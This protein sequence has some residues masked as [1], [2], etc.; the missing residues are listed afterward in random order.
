[1][2]WGMMPFRTYLD[3]TKARWTL[4]AADILFTNR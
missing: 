4:G 2:V 3:T 1:M